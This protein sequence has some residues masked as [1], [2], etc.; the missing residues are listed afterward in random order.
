MKDHR[1]YGQRTKI[2]TNIYE[3]AFGRTAIAK[4]GQHRTEKRFPLSTSQRDIRAWIE[5]RRAEFRK[6]KR[7]LTKLRGTLKGDVINYLATL[8]AGRPKTDTRSNLAAWLLALGDVKRQ[9][10][11]IEMLRGVVADWLEQDVAAST[12]NHRRRALIALYETLDG[13]DAPC[14]PRQLKR[15]R[16][17]KGQPRAVPMAILDAI[18]NTMEDDRGQ[19]FKGEK[20]PTARTN[21]SKARLR[22]LLWTG[23]PPSTLMRLHPSDVDLMGGTVTLP[24][25]AKGRGAP[26]VTLPLFPQGAEAFRGWLR[27]RAWGW[28]DQSALG[29]VFRKA[30]KRYT[31][32]VPA[33]RLPADLHA[34]DLR[35]SFLTWVYKQTRDA[36]TVKHFGQHQDLATTER[37]IEGGIPEAAQAAVDRVKQARRVD[38]AV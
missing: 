36:L 33:V 23:L 19:R 9:T 25:R 29:R 14:P 22:V 1:V 20:T 26:A 17:P 12:I 6:K 5:E 38:P 35:H 2:A 18:L 31:E 10:I 16:A 4:L 21:K 24:P 7:A 8:P 32:S 30:V 15:Q 11:T 28:F 34:Y 3:D 37:Y 13:P 27:A